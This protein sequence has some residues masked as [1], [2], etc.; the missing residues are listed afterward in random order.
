MIRVL[1][2]DD[3]P[4]ILQGLS[5]MLRSMRGEWHMEFACGGQEA[6]ALMDQ[7]DFDVIVSDMRMP[8]MDGVR[9]LNEVRE[10]HPATARVVLSGQAEQKMILEV[11]SITHQCLYKPCNEATLKDAIQR[12]CAM[13]D[14]L[15]SPQIKS[16][17]SQAQSLPSLPALY[18]EIVE[19]VQTNQASL[20]KIG[21]LIGR[22]MAMSSKV[23]QLI[24]SAF[25]GA[26]RRVAN[27]TQAVGLLGIETIK[28]LILSEG[29]FSA[30]PQERIAN[31]AIGDLWRHS[32]RTAS[33]ARSL[34]HTEGLEPKDCEE[35]FTAAFLHDT[36]KLILAL[37]LSSEYSEAFHLAEGEKLAQWQAEMQVF[38]TS[39][40]EIG[41]YL[42]SLWG[43]PPTIIYAIAW[44]HMP[45]L[46]NDGSFTV[47][48][49]VH[50]ANALE[51]CAVSGRE[52]EIACRLDMEYLGEIGLAA[53]IPAWAQLAAGCSQAE[54]ASCKA[55]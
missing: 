17:V 33:I 47:T 50:V 19:A 30:F 54:S 1:F 8:G 12:S 31:L 44:H 49:A 13:R 29:I 18:S 35:A 6:L 20:N 9:L 48:T 46:G 23:L 42:L 4:N 14:L 37:N 27:V 55:A 32:A 45:A 26:P 7:M 52:E 28:S 24:N 41:A 39:H 5:R 21:E 53:R 51:H 3:E 25:F 34:A 36:G 11:A 16:I 40:A 10:R 22:D 2:V 38:G 15:Q 43:L